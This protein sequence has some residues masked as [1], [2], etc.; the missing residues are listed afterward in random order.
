MKRRIPAASVLGALL[1]AAYAGFLIPHRTR[2]AGG[3]DSSGYLNTARGILE[4]R[5]VRDIPALRR[6][7]LPP[8]GAFPNLFIALGHVPGPR[9][10]TVA[11]F[12]PPGLPILMAGAIR[13]TG[14]P[15]AAY[16]VSPFF[17][18]L[19]VGLM[20][21]LL[22]DLG[23]PRSWS[24]M[25][26]FLLAS[27]PTW[28]F[29]ALQ[30]MSDVVATTLAIAAVLFARRARGSAAWAAAGGASLGLAVL[31]R[32]TN[33]LLIV[34]M[35]FA[36]PATRRAWAML[37]LGGLPFAI[38]LAVWN[39]TVYGSPFRSGYGAVLSDAMSL[40]FFRNHFA[41][42]FFWMSALT[43]GVVIAGWILAGFDARIGARDR[44]MLICW[45]LV[46]FAFYCF[47]GPY[48]TWWY[49]RFLMPGLPA[50]IAGSLL[51]GHHLLEAQAR[52]VRPPFPGRR[53]TAAA[54]ALGTFAAAAGV[55]YQADQGVYRF[56]RGE[57]IYLRASRMAERLVPP[58]G[59]VVAMQMTGALEYY[60]EVPY[61]MW[62][63]LDE[64]RLVVLDRALRERGGTWYALLAPFEVESVKRLFPGRWTELGR[65]G[66]VALWR[67]ERP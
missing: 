13:V 61:T 7:G 39:S 56:F 2:V 38:F 30:P 43:G 33:A 51:C 58:G 46:F 24:A 54:I 10:G 9:P 31:V 29:F 32:P 53:M 21:L 6:Y 37:S 4:G 35:L 28:T 59:L 49:T 27:F 25:G 60:T 11:P 15:D 45:L 63:W 44:A 20:F 23:L 5:V 1:L 62:N 12:Y 55:V 34:P 50:A 57:R 41:H 65:E 40:D 18:V 42:Y 36:L 48:E 14:S 8:D 22:R 67:L 47:Y 52:A 66:D 16:F 17:A 64:G 3:S 19:G 26:A